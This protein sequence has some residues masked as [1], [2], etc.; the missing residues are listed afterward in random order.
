MINPVKAK[1][2]VDFIYRPN[3]Q[4]IYMNYLFNVVQKALTIWIINYSYF[5]II[6]ILSLFLKN[7]SI[8][9]ALSSH[10]PTQTHSTIYHTTVQ[11]SEWK[12]EFLYAFLALSESHFSS[13]ELFIRISSNCHISWNLYWFH[14]LIYFHLSILI[15]LFITAL[16]DG[17]S[18]HISKWS[19]LN[20]HSL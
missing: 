17:V 11:L 5:I 18:A 20:P 12:F 2:F 9:Q 3:H 8:H 4:S 15:N 13:T 7:N 19:P 14:F 10:I 16:N 6:I 1:E